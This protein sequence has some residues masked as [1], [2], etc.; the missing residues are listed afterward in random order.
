MTK[1]AL[2]VVAFHGS[3]ITTKSHCAAGR[4]IV[5]CVRSEKVCAED[6]F[7]G[8]EPLRIPLHACGANTV[9]IRKIGQQ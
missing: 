5:V 6:V 9:E 4:F 2:L 3:D 8:F 1:D 7:D